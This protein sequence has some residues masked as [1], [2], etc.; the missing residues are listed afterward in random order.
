MIKVYLRNKAGQR[1]LKDA[2]PAPLHPRVEWVYV[3]KKSQLPKAAD[4]VVDLGTAQT[5]PKAEWFAAQHGCR[6]IYCLPEG[7]ELF[8]KV[9]RHLTQGWVSGIG[10][11]GQY[12][13]RILDASLY[14]VKAL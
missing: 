13:T 1:Q 8:Q 2:I 5:P 10:P 9:L 3:E 14:K 12:G 7:Q 4:L 6:I 11:D